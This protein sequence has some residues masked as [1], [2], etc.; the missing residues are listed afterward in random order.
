MRCGIGTGGDRVAG[1]WVV[2]PA[3]PLSAVLKRIRDMPLQPKPRPGERCELCAALIPDEH[4]HVVDLESRALMCACR[5]CY[6]VFAPQGAG[7]TRFRAVPD[8]Y[9]SFPDFALSPSQWDALQIPVGVAFFFMNSALDHVAAFYPSPAG[10]TESLL[11][12]DSWDEIV[13]ANPD[14]G[15]LQPDVE[16]FLVRSA[17]R[18]SGAAQAE[19]YLVPIDVCYELVGQLRRLWKGFDG[20]T[21]AH[22]ALDAFFDRVRDR[23]STGASREGVTW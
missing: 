18:Q 17:D 12:L 11:S 16:A 9:V 20:G 5:P 2:S 13:A 3:Q 8:R 10:A 6:L 4:G 14:L 15:T 22:A 19:C 7:G 21:E 1:C 23:A